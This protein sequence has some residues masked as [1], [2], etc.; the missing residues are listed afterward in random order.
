M[1]PSINADR[2][3]QAI[4]DMARI[5]PTPTPNPQPSTSSLQ[6]GEREYMVEEIVDR[7]YGPDDAFFK[8]RVR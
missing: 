6:L 7:C 8:V 3:W 5:G 4:M 2:L 1:T